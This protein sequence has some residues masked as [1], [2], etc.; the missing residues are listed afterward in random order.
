[1]IKNVLVTGGSGFIGNHLVRSLL[2]KNIEVFS[3]SSQKNVFKSSGLHNFDVRLNDKV[4]LTNLLSI[5]R[6][7]VVVHLA[8]IASPVYDN[9]SEIYETNV[10]GTENLFE[11]LRDSNLFGIK[12]ILTSTAGVYGNNPK[13]FIPENEPF[14]PVN[15]YSFSKM[16]MEIL[17]RRFDQDYDISI[18]R[19]FNIIGVGQKTNF[20]VPKLVQAFVNRNPI[21][22]VGN[23][24]TIRDYTPI[25]RAIDAIEKLIFE[26][27]E[28]KL[29]N[30]CS[31]ISLSGLDIIQALENITNFKPDIQV[32][33]DLIRPNEIFRCV[34][35]PTVIN[36]TCGSAIARKDIINTIEKM[37]IS[38][39]K[40]KME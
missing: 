40:F 9:V 35:D 30:I 27:T 39:N 14:S 10:L 33:P 1:M 34:G 24:N 16:V 38:S 20:L 4:A 31:G 29:L 5:I 25:K 36:R 2:N 22:E 6:P 32:S 3:L 15:H 18:I 11:S 13:E 37:V 26:N 21:I 23:L 12:V 19:P 17:S 8:A 28:L 7:D